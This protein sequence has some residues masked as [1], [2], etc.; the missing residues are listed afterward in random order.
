ML[1][2]GGSQFWEVHRK[3]RYFMAMRKLEFVGNGAALV[4]GGKVS[5]TT[6]IARS[7]TVTEF[8]VVDRIQ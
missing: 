5:M 8:S 7:D 4:V 3:W 1:I 6:N 2:L